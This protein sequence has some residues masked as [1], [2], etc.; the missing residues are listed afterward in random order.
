MAELELIPEVRAEV[1]K[2]IGETLAEFVAKTVGITEAP[3]W[4]WGVGWPLMYYPKLRKIL[5][6]D[7]VAVFWIRDREKTKRA[8]RYALGHEF[9]HY[10]QEVRGE[11]IIRVPI[12]DYPRLAEYIA[13]KQGVRLSGIT[14]VEGLRLW[15]ELFEEYAPERLESP[16]SLDEFSRKFEYE[17]VAT[18]GFMALLRETQ[19]AAVEEFLRE[20]ESHPRKEFFTLLGG[21]V[22]A[23][24]D[25]YPWGK[26]LTFLLPE[27]W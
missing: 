24:F 1:D 6:P 19:S 21:K 25:V 18:P 5:I 26:V 23:K 20:Y 16:L 15:R 7:I 13:E 27:E 11:W 2:Y 9:W 10:S 22:W 14:T 17:V 8:L 3:F 4:F 12:L